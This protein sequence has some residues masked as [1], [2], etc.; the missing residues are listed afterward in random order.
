MGKEA[1]NTGPA[2]FDALFA[3]NRLETTNNSSI[4]ALYV[5]KR[6]SDTPHY[7]GI[8]AD[9]ERSPNKSLVPRFAGDEGRAW[10]LAAESCTGS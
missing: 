6:E 9:V 1:G 5:S 4:F 2:I 8:R 7:R 10:R 3:F